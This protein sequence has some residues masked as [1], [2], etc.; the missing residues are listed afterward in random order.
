MPFDGVDG[1]QTFID[2][3]GGKITSIQAGS[4]ALST[5]Q[6][7]FGKTSLYLNGSSAVQV[8]ASNGFAF[9]LD[10]FTVEFWFYPLAHLVG[11]IS[12]RTVGEATGTWGLNFNNSGGFTFTEVI[13]GEPVLVSTPPNVIELNQWNHIAVSRKSGKTYAFVNGM[14]VG[15]GTASINFNNSAY[16][17]LI[18]RSAPDESNYLNCYIDDLRITKGVGRYTAQFDIPNQPFTADSNDSLILHFDGADGS[19]D[20]QDSSLTPQTVVANGSVH[21][22]TAQ[23]VFGSSSAIFNGT[24]DYLTVANTAA[25]DL[26]TSDFTIEAWVHKTNDASSTSAILSFSDG[27]TSQFSLLWRDTS[28]SFAI[29]NSSTTP[30]VLIEDATTRVLN[31]WYHVAF[32][33]KVDTIYL[34]VDG[35]L[36]GSTSVTMPQIVGYNLYIGQSGL[37]T[38]YWPGYIDEIR[39]SKNINRYESLITPPSEIMNDHVFP[40][41]AIG[42]AITYTKFRDNYDPYNETINNFIQEINIFMSTGTTNFNSLKSDGLRIGLP[43]STGGSQEFAGVGKIYGVVTENS[44]PISCLLRLYDNTSGALVAS[45]RSDQNGGYQF[46]NIKMSTTYTLVAYNPSKNYNSIIRDL[47][48]PERM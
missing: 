20:F 16:N 33:R 19:T 12:N 17:L 32:V 7:K 35:V 9:G 3:A 2:Y 25:I 44:Q 41:F 34:F 22:S 29:Y 39:I 46:E 24:T 38:E 48:K 30:S 28:S 42:N 14:L 26:G 36:V 23:S 8:Q 47:I 11:R 43:K 18:G 21:I 45:T 15:Y 27:S 31:N 40:G 6:K 5:T 37:S 1:Q 10:D 4:P 13:S